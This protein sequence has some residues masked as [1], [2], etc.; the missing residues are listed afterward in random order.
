MMYHIY[1]IPGKKIGVTTN[2]KIRVEKIQG[3]KKNEYEIL[4]ETNDINL[5]SKKNFIK[6]LL[7][8]FMKRQKKVLS[9]IME[10]NIKIFCL[11]KNLIKYYLC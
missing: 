2:P 8:Y 10:K 11:F 6:L 3:Y 4:L 7:I 9:M 1:H 5:V